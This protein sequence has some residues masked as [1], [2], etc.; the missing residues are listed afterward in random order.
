MTPI[1]FILNNNGICVVESYNRYAFK[2]FQAVT[3]SRK[4]IRSIEKTVI[5]APRAR[6]LLERLNKQDAKKV[7]H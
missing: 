2:E 7:I 1:A 5:P 6:E 4:N 3:H